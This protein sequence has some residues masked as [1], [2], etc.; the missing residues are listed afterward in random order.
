MSDDHF[1]PPNA[2]ISNC[3]E[4][5]YVGFWRRAFASIIDSIIALIILLPLFFMFFG[6]EELES[7]EF[8]FSNP[9]GIVINYVIPIGLTVFFW[10]VFKAT[11]GKM[12]MGCQ[13]VNAETGEKLGV[14]RSIVRYIG[15][16]ISTIPLGLGFLWIVFN[17]RKRGWHD[18]I[19]G[20]VVIRKPD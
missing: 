15:Y 6:L 1:T 5:V 19:A 2:N 10:T 17:K 7:E 16:I 4:M 13:V 3:Q 14:G 9:V 20:T 11:P 8:N 18:L 12:A